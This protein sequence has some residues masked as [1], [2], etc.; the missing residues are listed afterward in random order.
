MPLFNPAA[1]SD[2]D[3]LAFYGDI[4]S[5]TRQAYRHPPNWHATQL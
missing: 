4:F 5:L 1:E 3:Q 2:L